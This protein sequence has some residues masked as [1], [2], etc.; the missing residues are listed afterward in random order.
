MVSFAFIKFTRRALI[1]KKIHTLS[2]ER[3][4]IALIVSLITQ[5]LSSET[6]PPMGSLC[7]EAVFVAAAGS[8]FGSLFLTETNV[9]DSV[10]R[11]ATARRVITFSFF[12]NSRYQ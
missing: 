8:G 10:T 6:N 9:N 11:V 5:N 12:I 2:L 4:C 7:T 3:V 1:D